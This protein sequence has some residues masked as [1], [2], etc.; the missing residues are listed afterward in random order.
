MSDDRVVVRVS[1]ETAKTLKAY[2][3]TKE[4][5]EGEVARAM[6]VGEAADAMIATAKSRLA[7]LASYAKKAPKKPSKKKSK[8]AD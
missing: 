8:K 2:A 7:S 3:N 1:P 6:T 5:V 4:I